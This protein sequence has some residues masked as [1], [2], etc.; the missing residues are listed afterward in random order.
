MEDDCDR[1]MQSS[2]FKASEAGRKN[3]ALRSWLGEEK[4]ASWMGRGKVKIEQTEKKK[5]VNR[6]QKASR[7]RQR[8]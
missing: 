7:V 4:A 6:P 1:Q 2:F 3:K 5:G 8:A